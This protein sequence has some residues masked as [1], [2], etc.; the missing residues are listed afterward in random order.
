MYAYTNTYTV[1][2]TQS[3]KYGTQTYMYTYKKRNLCTHIIVIHMYT[4]TYSHFSHT[5][6]N[7]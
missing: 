4:V 2:H 1:T 7:T 6:T 5:Y 3:T